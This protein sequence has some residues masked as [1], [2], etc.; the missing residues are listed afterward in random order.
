[1]FTYAACA[2]GCGCFGWMRR[3]WLIEKFGDVGF[4]ADGAFEDG[5]NLHEYVRRSPVAKCRRA[6]PQ[7][8]L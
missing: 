4:A 5:A 8:V 6:A 1:M 2:T 3:L 7:H